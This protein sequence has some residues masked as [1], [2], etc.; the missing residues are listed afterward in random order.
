MVGEYHV[1]AVQETEDAEQASATSGVVPGAADDAGGPVFEKPCNHCHIE[2][3]MMPI[4]WHVRDGRRPDTQTGSG[5]SVS[6][7]ELNT[8]F[9]SS[10]PRFLSAELPEFNVNSPSRYPLHV[11]VEVQSH[12]GTDSRFPKAGFYL[13]QGLSPERVQQ[14][15]RDSRTADTGS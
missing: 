12:E 15:L 8:L 3:K 10:D 5:V 1:A 13:L 2:E 4:L 6:F 11:V 14:Q 7:Q 9:A